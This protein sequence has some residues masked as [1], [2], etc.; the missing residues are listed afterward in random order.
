[1]NITFKKDT[2]KFNIKGRKYYFNFLK[3]YFNLNI[4]V[5]KYL[6]LNFVNLDKLN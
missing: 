4:F 3:F 5:N 1:M 2:F 6:N